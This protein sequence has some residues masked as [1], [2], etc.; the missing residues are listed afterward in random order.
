[1]NIVRALFA[2]LAP[3]EC[4]VCYA[5]GDLLCQDCIKRIKTIGSLEPLSPI[6]H[7]WAGADYEG[8]AK[9][10]LHLYKFERAGEA[11]STLVRIMESSLPRLPTDTVVTYIPT[12]TKRIRQR[13]YDQARRLAADL[14]RSQGLTLKPLLV[15]IG[16]QHQVGSS[17][18][19]R[20]AQARQAY[21]VKPGVQL[22]GKRILLVDDI[23][24]TGS[25]L[26]AA[27]EVLMAAG[28]KQVDAAVMGVKQKSKP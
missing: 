27:A 18:V 22:A 20:Q 21:V 7:I 14:A 3:F 2:F 16:Q 13:G 23:M 28:A 10:L 11:S 17:R 4:L 1:V 24:T 12:A 19:E 15:R 5:E 6:S 26:Q 8:V 9:Q 25:T